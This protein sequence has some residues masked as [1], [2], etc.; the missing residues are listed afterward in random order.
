MSHKKQMAVRRIDL[1]SGLAFVL[2]IAAVNGVTNR[3][4]APQQTFAVVRCDCASRRCLCTEFSTCALVPSQQ[5]QKEN[6][7]KTKHNTEPLGIPETLHGM[8]RQQIVL[9]S[10]FPPI[11]AQVFNK[12]DTYVFI[13][14]GAYLHY[15]EPEGGKPALSVIIR[16]Q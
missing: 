12:N 1:S 13:R 15:M 14:I 6:K 9:T 11:R 2:S 4:Y 5:K 16:V 10:R 3:G 7:K 8:V